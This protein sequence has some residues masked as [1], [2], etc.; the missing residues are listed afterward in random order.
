VTVYVQ[1]SKLRK[2]VGSDD[3]GGEVVLVLVRKWDK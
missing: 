3:E 1:G 2:N